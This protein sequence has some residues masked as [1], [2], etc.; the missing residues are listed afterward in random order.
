MNIKR[1]CVFCGSAQGNKPEYAE[2]GRLLGR[3]LVEH[4]IQ[5]VYGAG[6]VGMMGV[7]ADAVL[8]AGGQATGVIPQALVEKELAHTGLTQMHVVETMHQRKALMVELSD[9][10]VALPGGYGTLDE[11]FEVLTW[12]QLGMHSKPIGLLNIG[13]YFDALLGWLDHA[14]AE[15]FLR[16]KHHQLL[17]VAAKPEVMIER[18]LA[19]RPVPRVDK[20]IEAKDV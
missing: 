19:F 4:G 3:L 10:F 13:G 2:N 7:L 11:L 17:I 5:L 6:H 12:A 1:L 18:I 20:W 9:G 14:L 16:A 8:Q 15:G